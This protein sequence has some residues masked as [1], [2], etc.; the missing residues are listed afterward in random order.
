MLSE[1]T[2]EPT[3]VQVHLMA[4]ERLTNRHAQL[5]DKILKENAHKSKYWIL[6]M[7]HITKKY[8]KSVIKP[9]LKAYD[10]QPEV[11]KSAFLYEVDNTKGTKTLL[12]VMHPNNT[13]D[14][15][16]MGKSIRVSGDN[17]ST[18][19]TAEVTAETRE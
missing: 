17:G 14:L 15:P 7:A 2:T 19:L 10:V 16:S 11:R 12:W 1:I 5:M 4:R 18:N 3:I 9:H 8:R 6:G 13:L